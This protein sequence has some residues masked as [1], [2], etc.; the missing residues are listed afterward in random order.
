MRHWLAISLSF[1]G[2]LSLLFM[3]RPFRMETA[4][5]E[6]IPRS[7]SMEKIGEESSYFL[8]CP[9]YCHGGG[10]DALCENAIQHGHE[11]PDTL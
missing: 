8:G 6:R 9:D 1:E 10:N 7:C 5:S 11:K 2:F 3:A 4:L